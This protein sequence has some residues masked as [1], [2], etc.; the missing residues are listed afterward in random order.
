MPGSKNAR[1]NTTA[2]KT[3]MQALRFRS[4]TGALPVVEDL[5]LRLPQVSGVVD[6]EPFR[7]QARGDAPPPAERL[8]ASRGLRTLHAPEGSTLPREG[9]AG[10]RLIFVI[11][12]ELAVTT[13]NRG[14]LSLRPGELA[15]MDTGTI[16]EQCTPRGDCRLIQVLVDADWPDAK[17]L[18]LDPLSSHPRGTLP[19]NVKRMVKADDDRSVYREFPGLFPEV[20]T[21]SALTPL[22]GFRFL[23][24]LDTVIDW[25]PEVVNN[26][27]IVLSGALE[28]EVG[29]EGGA[30]EVFREGDVCL[31]EDRTG[32]GHIDRT[33]G[34][35]RVA[36]LV[37]ADADL[38]PQTD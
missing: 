8:A 12:G 19:C 17:A 29:G 3:D 2:A 35:V 38:W 25:H 4:G 27:V 20:G 7:A 15:L 37:I 33:H 34:L 31:A 13:A 24:M 11:S 23:G 16:L 14:P 10:P 21:W 5:P 26:L 22:V 30:V 9:S 1:R 6:P 18:A 28:L 32:E 36:I